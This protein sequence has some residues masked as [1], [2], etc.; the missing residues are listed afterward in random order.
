MRRDTHFL[1]TGVCGFVASLLESKLDTAARPSIF[2]SES[3][4]TTT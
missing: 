3:L 1:A 2:K 4:N